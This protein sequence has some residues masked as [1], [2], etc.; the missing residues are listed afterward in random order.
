LEKENF[1]EGIGAVK[2]VTSEEVADIKGKK[3][4]G[5]DL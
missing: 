3:L 1:A 2:S 4:N 5:W